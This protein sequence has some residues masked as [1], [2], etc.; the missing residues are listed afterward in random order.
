MAIIAG[1]SDASTSIAQSQ[2]LLAPLGQVWFDLSPD[3]LNLAQAVIQRHIHP[4]L[5]D[6]A[7]Q[8]V[9]TWPVWAV[10]APLGLL[11]LWLGASRR[12]QR[13]QFA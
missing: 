12:R 7:L 10:F 9:L 6:P 2:V 8:T 11:F 1:I 3:T 4:A 5:W 13:A